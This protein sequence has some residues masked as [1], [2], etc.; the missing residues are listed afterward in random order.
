MILKILADNYKQ[1]RDH[2]KHA[3][4]EGKRYV[5]IVTLYINFPSTLLVQSHFK[6]TS[7]DDDCVHDHLIK[8]LLDPSKNMVQTR[9]RLQFLDPEVRNDGKEQI[10]RKQLGNTQKQPAK[11]KTTVRFP[12]SRYH[13][14]LS[15]LTRR[16]TR[17]IFLRLVQTERAFLICIN[18]NY[19]CNFNCINFF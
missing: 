12:T 2:S 4:Y 16:K 7:I 3:M 13:H 10:T 15:C 9:N 1:S 14:G 5:H 11:N 17:L 8:L 18:P 19:N 6:I